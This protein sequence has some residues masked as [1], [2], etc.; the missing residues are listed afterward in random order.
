MPSLAGKMSVLELKARIPRS[1][2]PFQQKKRKESVIYISPCLY[3]LLSNKPCAKTLIYRISSEKRKRTLPSIYQHLKLFLFI[4]R[5]KAVL[6]NIL[7]LRFTTPLQTCRH[8]LRFWHRLRFQA[9]ALSKKAERGW[10]CQR[11]NQNNQSLDPRAFPSPQRCRHPSSSYSSCKPQQ[12]CSSHSL[13]AQPWRAAPQMA[14]QE[15][16]AG[17][18]CWML[19]EGE[20]DNDAGCHARSGTSWELSGDQIPWLQNTLESRTRGK[21][22][23]S[24][25]R[26]YKN[27]QEQLPRPGPSCVLRATKRSRK[28]V[29]HWESAWCTEGSAVP[30]PAL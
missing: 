15:E 10:G 2:P 11:D 29:G 14:S 5:T 3:G 24:G 17:D 6:L 19:V 7:N 20:E 21:A 28:S 30:L 13:S 4:P 9:I 23:L 8:C 26:G 22:G 12:G 27:R 25:A 16:E 1:E 18:A